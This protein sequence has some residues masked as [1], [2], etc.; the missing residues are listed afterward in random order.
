MFQ[1]AIWPPSHA[2]HQQHDAFQGLALGR[3]AHKGT[4]WKSCLP[5]AL[6]LA[7]DAGDAF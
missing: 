6:T 3:A 2:L 5:C 1:V 4:F 7:G